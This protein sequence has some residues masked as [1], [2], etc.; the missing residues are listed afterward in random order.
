MI[1]PI[2]HRTVSAETSAEVEDF[3]ARA[4]ELHP[5]WHHYTW[6]DPLEPADFP[7][8]SPHWDRCTSGAQRAGLIRLE[9]LYISGGVYIDSDL[10]LYRPL[11][12]LL[13]L[14]C[15][16]GWE[17]PRTVPDFVIGAESGRSILLELLETAITR[18][19]KGPW[20][21]GPGVF[22]ELLPGRAD[23]LLL[24]PGSFAPY[25]YTEKHRRHEDHRSA[26]PWA[27]GAHHWHH[28]WAG[29]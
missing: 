13:S 8:S 22:T 14:S 7:R 11:D 24:P 25:H 29:T 27:F 6:R 17:D 16:A 18:L 19:D 9:A 21:S 23:V 2:L 10:E 5:D 26:Q 3:W 1:P 20:E 12:P 4:C 28:S 15:F